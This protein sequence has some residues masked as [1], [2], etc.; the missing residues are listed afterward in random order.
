MKSVHSDW[1]KGESVL[2]SLA[3]VVQISQRWAKGD[4]RKEKRETKK[5]KK[6]NCHLERRVPTVRANIRALGWASMWSGECFP[7]RSGLATVQKVKRNGSG[8]TN[9]TKPDER[10]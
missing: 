3:L 6:A 5:K 7:S 8:G 2:S 4:R 10:K 9:Q 1:G